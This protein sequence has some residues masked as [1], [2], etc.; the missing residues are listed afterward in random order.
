MQLRWSG[1]ERHER[2]YNQRRTVMMVLALVDW[3]VVEVLSW[4]V[5]RRIVGESETIYAAMLRA[6]RVLLAEQLS[7][8]MTTV[9]G[10]I[11]VPP[12]LMT[13]KLPL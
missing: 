11:A 7:R 4:L 10:G 1:G 3:L 13:K 6:H 8:T 9:V 12:P 5:L 2:R